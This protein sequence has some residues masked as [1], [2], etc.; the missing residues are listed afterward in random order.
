MSSEGAYEGVQ[1]VQGRTPQLGLIWMQD[2][3]LLWNARCRVKMHVT[4]C[5]TNASMYQFYGILMPC[6]Y[7]TH[8]GCL[9]STIH[10]IYIQGSGYTTFMSHIHDTQY[11]NLILMIYNIYASDPR[12]TILRSITHDTQY[13]YLKSIIWNIYV[14]YQRYTIFMSGILYTQY[15]CLLSLIHN[16]YMKW[17]NSGVINLTIHFQ[18]SWPTTSECFHNF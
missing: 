12:H 4:H 15:L 2:G 17:S 10:N 8:Y 6:I 16:I 13:L 14:W 11:L 7:D 3:I 9:V 5:N 1:G 18:P